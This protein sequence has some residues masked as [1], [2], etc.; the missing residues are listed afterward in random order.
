MHGKGELKTFMINEMEIMNWL[1]HRKIIRL[2]DAFETKKSLSLVIELAAGGELVK[3]NLLKQQYYT[4]SEI[5]G[6]IRQVL[7]GL[8]H[9]HEMNIGHMGLTVFRYL[10]VILILLKMYLSQII[11]SGR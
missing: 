10:K 4:E 11:I 9:M 6:Y 2:H 1:N 5:A 7:W 8:E 3:D